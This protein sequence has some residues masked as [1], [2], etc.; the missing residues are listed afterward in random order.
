ME[1]EQEARLLAWHGD[2][3]LKAYA[4]QK[5]KEHQAK[6]EIIRGA[7]LRVAPGY[8]VSGW[9]GC[10]HGCL[11]TDRLME[12][13]DL[14]ARELYNKMLGV[15]ADDQRLN[16][17]VEARRLWGFP[18]NL[19]HLLDV[20]FESLTSPEKAAIFA[21]EVT[22]A[23]PVGADLTGVL[24]QVNDAM[25]KYEGSYSDYYDHQAAALIEALRNAPV[26]E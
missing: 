4:T 16:Y 17:H 24:D 10:F 13:N 2:P 19:S 8:S 5:M 26:P 14:S 12:E 20:T 6:D 22:E 23:I 9:R 7:Y 11:T 18:T 15:Y 25:D 21:V 1:L 3:E